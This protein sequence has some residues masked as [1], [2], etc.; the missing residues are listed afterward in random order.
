MVDVTRRAL[1]PLGFGFGAAIAGIAPAQA[2][3]SYKHLV[4]GIIPA[5]DIEN[6]R[7]AAVALFTQYDAGKIASKDDALLT[8]ADILFTPATQDIKTAFI[9]KHPDPDRKSVV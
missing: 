1:G 4:P 6:L 2:Q 7:K 8:P 9:L 3:A 5:S